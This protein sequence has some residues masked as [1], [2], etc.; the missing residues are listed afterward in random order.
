MTDSDNSTTPPLVTRRRMLVGTAIALA[1]SKRK[2]FAGTDLEID[3][4]ADP[5]IAAWGKWQAAHQRTERL[6]RQQQRL[7]RKLAETVGFPCTTVRLH[8][9]ENARLYSLEALTE[10]LDIAPAE[11]AVRGKAEADFAAHQAHWDAADRE[12]GYSATLRAEREAADRA[13]DLLELLSKTPAASLAGVAAKLDAV[14]REGQS[15]QADTEF[16][17]P[18][19]RSAFDDIGRI[20]R[21]GGLSQIFGPDGS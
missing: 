15:S 16:P 20:S 10:M 3:L 2:A 21:Q 7:E 13:E 17:W 4:S 14:L 1:G 6:C 5:A 18:Q 8:D 12:I 11:S 19:I 9:G